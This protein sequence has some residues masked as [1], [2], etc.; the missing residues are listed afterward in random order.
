MENKTLLHICKVLSVDDDQHGLRI[1]VR[2]PSLDDPETPVDELPYAFPLMPKHLHVNPKKDE[3]VLVI[4]QDAGVSDGNRFFVGPVI[5]QPQN[6]KFDP[7]NYTATTMLNGWQLKAMKDPDMN[8]D[9]KGT[10]PEREDVAIE[11]RDNADLILKENEVRLRCGFKTNDYGSFGDSLTFNK[12]DLAY[13]QM[14]YSKMKD[15]NG[16][17]YSSVINVVA[18]RINLLSHDSRTDFK[19]NDPEKLITEQEL[20]RITE[21]AHPVAYGDE[22]V[23]LLKKIVHVLLNHTHSF[24]MNVPCQQTSLE[25]INYDAILSKSIKIN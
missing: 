15:S 23:E 9:T 18:D 4:F 11:G 7:Y 13:I 25:N 20:K 5:S 6:L 1:K 8:P 16:N 21:N 19:L 17:A 12:D 22:L 2:I 10:L 14:K 24:P 3:C